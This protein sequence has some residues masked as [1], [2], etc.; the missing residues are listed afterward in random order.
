M[1]VLIEMTLGPAVQVE[2]VPVF[3]HGRRVALTCSSL[4]LVICWVQIIVINTSQEVRLPRTSLV[5]KR[6]P[7]SLP[8]PQK[9]LDLS[10]KGWYFI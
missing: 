1:I 2:P 4:R 9:G 10:R 7:P 3:S 5:K 8:A 6:H